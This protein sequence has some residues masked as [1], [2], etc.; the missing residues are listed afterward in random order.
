MNSNR[1]LLYCSRSGCVDTKSG[2][3][4]VIGATHLSAEVGR[5]HEACPARYDA[6]DFLG[7]N[8]LTAWSP[9]I[10]CLAPL[11]FTYFS[12]LLFS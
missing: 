11:M 1:G 7:F 2:V 9:I 8:C 4:F 10:Q 5:F 12:P 6:L 3:R